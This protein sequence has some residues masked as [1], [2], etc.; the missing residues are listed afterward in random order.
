MVQ[1]NCV[2]DNIAATG[3][4]SLCF[5]PGS[6]WGALQDNGNDGKEYEIWLQKVDGIENLLR[7]RSNFSYGMQRDYFDHPN[8]IGWTREGDHEHSGCAVLLSTGDDGTKSMEMGK[9]YS[10][11]VFIDM[12]GKNPGEVQ[13]N[14]EG[15]GEF[16]APAG[17]LSVWISK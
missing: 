15:W 3:R 2:C 16:Y 10:G 17:S 6:L 5:L 11:K 9:R 14:E 4:F 1:A 8:C 13:I 7:A 12:M